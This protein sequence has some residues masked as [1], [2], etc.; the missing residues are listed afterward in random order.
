LRRQDYCH[1]EA[2]KFGGKVFRHL[3]SSMGC[4]LSADITVAP[5][6]SQSENASEP[7]VS[8]GYVSWKREKAVLP[9][10]EVTTVF[11]PEAFKIAFLNSKQVPT[12]SP[13]KAR[14]LG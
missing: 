8:S 13:I 11:W 10:P 9:G 1:H 7:V 3:T 2:D 14:Q 12:L 5:I 6:S 4:G